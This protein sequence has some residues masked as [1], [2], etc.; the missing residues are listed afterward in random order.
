MDMD[1]RGKPSSSGWIRQLGGVPPLRTAGSARPSA[2]A[3][4]APNH[5]H[6]LEETELHV[7]AA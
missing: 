7:I 1:S 5:T 4:R 2:L 6:A 3:Y